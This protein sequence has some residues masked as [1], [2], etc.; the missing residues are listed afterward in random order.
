ML[1]PKWCKDMLCSLG[2]DQ[3]RSTCISS[4]SAA[5][6]RICTNTLTFNWR[7]LQ[8]RDTRETFLRSEDKDEHGA[9]AEMIIPNL[10]PKS[11]WS[12]VLS[13]RGVN[14]SERIMAQ[15]C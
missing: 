11:T 15:L 6:D 12:D 10:L 8:S 2:V 1:C 13:D 14:H 7:L 9:A 5:S 4:S 3:E